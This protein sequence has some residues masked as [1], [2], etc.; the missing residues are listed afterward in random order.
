MI[1]S[2]FFLLDF[3]GNWVPFQFLWFYCK[4]NRKINNGFPLFSVMGNAS[5]REEGEG[6]SSGVN[7]FQENDESMAP[8]PPH[9]RFF[10]SQNPGDTLTRPGGAIQT[11]THALSQNIEYNDNVQNRDL[12]RMKISWT[13][14][15]RQAAITGSWD[16]WQT[17]EPLQNLGNEFVVIKLL[18]SGF[19]QYRFIVDGCWRCAPDLPWIYDDSGTAYNVLDLQ[20]YG[21][22]LPE[23]L[24][25]FESPPSPPSSYDNRCLSENDFSKPPPEV[26]PQ[27]QVP[28]LN[29]PPSSSNDG[30][31]P[32]SMPHYSQLNHLYIQ[33]Q[34]GGEYFALSSTHRF[35]KKFVTMVLYKPLNRENP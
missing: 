4:M 22:E 31:R 20:E 21:L 15:G 19:Y 11:Q 26:P 27:L 2:V 28:F 24:S 23:R 18:P 9:N 14:G 35:R 32:F 12:R 30:D 1:A 3:S 7:N 33:N 29:R 17:R 16:N 6:S 5:G 10:T 34:I 8:S 25:K 13:H